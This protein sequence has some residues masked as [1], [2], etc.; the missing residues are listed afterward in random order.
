MSGF[1]RR[2]DFNSKLTD[3]KR[4]R[5]RRILI[6]QMPR[7]GTSIKLAQKAKRSYVN[8]SQPLPKSSWGSGVVPP[9]RSTCD[10][11]LGRSDVEGMLESCD[12]SEQEIRIT[13]GP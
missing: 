11:G 6:K 3:S 10:E 7:Q 8:H 13:N 9:N 1:V 12:R 2:D 4:G 5:I